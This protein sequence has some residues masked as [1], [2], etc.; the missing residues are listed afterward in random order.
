[1]SKVKDTLIGVVLGL[2]IVAPP[3][4]GV[5]AFVQTTAKNLEQQ[6]ISD[7]F[8]SEQIYFSDLRIVIPINS[9]RYFKEEYVKDVG[10]SLS[11]LNLKYSKS[12]NTGLE[13]GVLGCS[14]QID[15]HLEAIKGYINLIDEDLDSINTVFTLGH[16]RGH[17][18]FSIGKQNLIYQQFQNPIDVESRIGNTEDFA[19]LCGYLALKNKGYNLEDIASENNDPTYNIKVAQE[20]KRIILSSRF[21][22]N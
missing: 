8:K 19:N 13:R 2:S 4:Y 20:I 21:K 1:M 12:K 10:K 18:L 7:G 5:K 17:F 14:T 11:D 3:Y 22:N 16:E 15:N 9:N 6:L